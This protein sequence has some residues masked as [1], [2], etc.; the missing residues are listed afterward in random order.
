MNIVATLIFFLANEYMFEY[1]LR[2]TGCMIGLI[3]S[4]LFVFCFDFFLGGGGKITVVWACVAQRM[5]SHRKMAWMLFY[6]KLGGF[7]FV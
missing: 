6:V 1:F 4:V 7:L 3:R 2:G 5:M